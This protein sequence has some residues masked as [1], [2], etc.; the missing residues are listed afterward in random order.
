MIYIHIH[1]HSMFIF[2]WCYCWYANIALWGRLI[3]SW[4]EQSWFPRSWTLEFLSSRVQ[5]MWSSFLDLPMMATFWEAPR[6]SPRYHPAVLEKTRTPSSAPTSTFRR[7]GYDHFEHCLWWF[8]ML[9]FVVLKK[10]VRA[11][12]CGM[13]V[14]F[15][16]GLVLQAVAAREAQDVALLEE[17]L[18]RPLS[19]EESSRIGI[20][21]LRG[22]LEE[23]LQRR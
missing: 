6:F 11:R 21:R 8:K 23:L 14:F 19:S 16:N 7:C 18:N 9:E 1:I 15:L 4:A 17:K 10:S 22:F 12:K 13:R 5:M 3:Q 2:L 20:S